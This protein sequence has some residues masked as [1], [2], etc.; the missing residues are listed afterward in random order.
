V[1]KGNVKTAMSWSPKI[2]QI[3]IGASFEGFKF[4]TFTICQLK[5]NTN[6]ESDFGV[7]VIHFDCP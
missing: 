4:T 7:N 1:R 6:F 3:E 5:K 2:T